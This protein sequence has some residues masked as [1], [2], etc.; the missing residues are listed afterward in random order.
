MK[1]IYLCGFMGC[2]KS[3]VGRLAAKQM[4]MKFLDL[5][6]YIEKKYGCTIPEIFEQRGEQAFRALETETLRE[7]ATT[8]GYIIATGGGTMVSSLN[9]EIAKQNG[10]IVFLDLPF[11]TCYERI[12]GDSNRPV[13]QS[14]SRAGL[15]EIFNYRVP[16][17]RAHATY[18][19]D[20]SQSPQM[21]S[22]AIKQLYD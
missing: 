6:E 9:A 21:I 15:L 20:A 12:A 4:S 19:V 18:S 1:N 13:V 22:K 5:D 14:N 10:S 11:D 8:S 2:G 3:T 16:L 17:Y 7:L